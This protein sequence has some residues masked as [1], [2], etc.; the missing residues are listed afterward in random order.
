MKNDKGQST[1]EYILLLAVVTSLFFTVF[2]SEMFQKF[3]GENSSFFQT[4][5]ERI[6]MNYRYATV[7]DIGDD[8]PPIPPDNHPSFALPDGSA[9]RFFGYN[10]E[11]VYP[12]K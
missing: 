6:A 2:R 5:A 1:V 11:T 12:P 10:D 4:I 3:F 9:S 8:V 7:V